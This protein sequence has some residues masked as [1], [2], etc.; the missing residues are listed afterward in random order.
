[1]NTIHSVF[2]DNGILYFL[3]ADGTEVSVDKSGET[4][5]NGGRYTLGGIT[6]SLVETIVTIERGRH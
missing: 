3:F 6:K 4:K 2:T 1:M 5:V